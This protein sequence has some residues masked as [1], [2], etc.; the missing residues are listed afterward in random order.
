MGSGTDG[1]RSINTPS[2][3]EDV[4]TNI[5]FDYLHFYSGLSILNLAMALKIISVRKL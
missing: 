4:L 5:L 1:C 2:Y 3:I